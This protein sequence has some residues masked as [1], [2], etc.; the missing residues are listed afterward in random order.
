MR[1]PNA[2]WP[3]RLSTSTRI[4]G[5]LREICI[6]FSLSRVTP[7]HEIPFRNSTGNSRGQIPEGARRTRPDLSLWKCGIHKCGAGGAAALPAERPS[8][9]PSCHRSP[10]EFQRP[11][12]GMRREQIFICSRSRPSGMSPSPGCHQVTTKHGFFEHKTWFFWTRN[13]AF[14][15]LTRVLSRSVLLGPFAS[16]FPAAR[17]FDRLAFREPASDAF[18]P[19]AWRSGRRQAMPLESIVRPS[20][21]REYGRRCL[22]V[23]GATLH[24]EGQPFRKLDPVFEG[25]PPE[26]QWCLD[27]NH[28]H[29]RSTFA[30]RTL[31][32]REKRLKKALKGLKMGTLRP[33]RWFSQ[34]NF[35]G[36]PQTPTL[37]ENSPRHGKGC[38]PGA[39]VHAG[40]P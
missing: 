8:R 11:E 24:P 33:F 37:P 19:I 17:A 23:P 1:R 14:L 10:G 21:L 22:C 2:V 39:M 16:L 15:S 12:S 7:P 4:W 36:L 13:I 3:Y 26:N 38:P 27:D 5:D 20:C 25:L 34:A 28:C 30:S 31:Q 40:E 6:F 9:L 35:K 32:S 29:P 18:R